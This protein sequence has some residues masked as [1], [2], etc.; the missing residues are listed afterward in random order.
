MAKH[1]ID[2]RAAFFAGAALLCALIL[3]I[4]PA[5]FRYVGIVLIVTYLLL[6][7]LSWLDFRGRA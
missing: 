3:P 5:D 4:T 6:A 1:H 2:R 7:L